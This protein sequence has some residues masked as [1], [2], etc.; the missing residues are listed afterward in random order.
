[1]S[2]SGDEWSGHGGGFA[3]GGPLCIT[4]I[5]ALRTARLL[6]F[7]PWAAAERRGTQLLERG[8]SALAP[9]RALAPD[10]AQ[11]SLL[12]G[13]PEAAVAG[14]LDAGDELHGNGQGLL[15]LFNQDYR[16]SFHPED[17]AA[18]AVEYNSERKSFPTTEGPGVSVFLRE[19][20]DIFHTCSTYERGLDVFIT[21]YNYLDLTPL[22]R[23]EEGLPYGMA[24]VRH[25][26]RYDAA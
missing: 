16:V 4:V 20:E 9:A 2:L 26:D 6:C 21:P 18:E 10:E 3:A 17:V 24:W 23:Q 12:S 1:M 25:H 8:K 15:H 14:P 13:A 22:G 11:P 5:V 19:G 7:R